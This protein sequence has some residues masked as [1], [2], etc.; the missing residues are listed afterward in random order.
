MER[1]FLSRDD[2]KR[3]R[4]LREAWSLRVASDKHPG[5][6]QQNV[7][8]LD[9][10]IRAADEAELQARRFTQAELVLADLHREVTRAVRRGKLGRRSLTRLAEQLDAVHDILKP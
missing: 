7:A 4:L 9:S 1:A 6:L 3:L 2:R 10:A 8:A 5:I